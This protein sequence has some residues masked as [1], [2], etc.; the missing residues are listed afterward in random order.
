[1]PEPKCNPMQFPRRLKSGEARERERETVKAHRGAP[2][3]LLRLRTV[4]ARFG[5]LA[6]IRC[7]S[8]LTS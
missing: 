8:T 7:W 4:P 6:V 5:R 2:C 1:V 3:A